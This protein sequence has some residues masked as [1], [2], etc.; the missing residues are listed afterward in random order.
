MRWIVI[1]ILLL[2]CCSNLVA[3][4]NSELAYESDTTIREVITENPVKYCN[5]KGHALC[6]RITAKEV[7]E[8]GSKGKWSRHWKRMSY[9]G[10]ACVAEHGEKKGKALEALFAPGHYFAMT[11]VNIAG[12]AKYAFTLKAKRSLE[13]QLGIDHFCGSI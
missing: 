13:E 12:L 11:F 3:Q 10:E 8:D 2:V 6:I 9:I 4:E 7:F 5:A 1:Q